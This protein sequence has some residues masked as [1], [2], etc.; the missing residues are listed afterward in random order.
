M[1]IIANEW[2]PWKSWQTNNFLCRLLCCKLPTLGL[3]SQ[4]SSCCTTS[5]NSICSCVLLTDTVTKGTDYANRI[6][7]SPLDLKTFHGACKSR[8]HCTREASYLDRT[9]PGGVELKCAVND[10][11]RKKKALRASKTKDFIVFQD[12]FCIRRCKEDFFFKS[13]PWLN[14]LT[15]S[16]IHNSLIHGIR[17]VD[18]NHQNIWWST[19]LFFLRNFVYFIFLLHEK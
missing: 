8:L 7:V 9:H 2:F 11:R 18:Q 19:K 12:T 13:S 14:W 16:S 4:S 1:E 6:V 5:R 15:S 10:Q 17:T 3:Q